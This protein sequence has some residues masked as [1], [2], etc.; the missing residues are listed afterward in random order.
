MHLQSAELQALGK[1]PRK[2]YNKKSGEI[3]GPK[4]VYAHVGMSTSPSVKSS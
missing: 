3:S 4:G 2:T 1:L